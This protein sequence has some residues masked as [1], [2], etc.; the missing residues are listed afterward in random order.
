MNTLA[1][2][3]EE[4]LL[5]VDRV[6]AEELLA[7]ASNLALADRLEQVVVP[8]LDHIGRSWEE[9]AVALSQVYMAG[10]IAEELVAALAPARPKGTTPRVALALLEDHHQ[11]GKRMVHSVLLAAGHDVADLGRVTVDELVAQVKEQHFEVVLVSVLMLAS[12]K[13]VRLVAEQLALLPWAVTL[14]VGGAPFRLDPTLA[15]RLGAHAFGAN[16]ADALR[17][18]DHALGAKP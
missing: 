15:G 4:A 5:A 14:V 6:A 13:R 7:Q 16:A 2:R 10:R 11:L 17:L 9:G 12:A 18:V 1:H 8:A 3:F